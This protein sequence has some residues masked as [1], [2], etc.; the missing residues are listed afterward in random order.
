MIKKDVILEECSVC[1]GQVPRGPGYYNGTVKY[2]RLICSGC[3]LATK[4]SIG[5]AND[6]E[7][8]QKVEHYCKENDLEIPKWIKNEEELSK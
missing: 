4:I 2:G 1:K 8:V 7:S 6:D 3:V 5:V